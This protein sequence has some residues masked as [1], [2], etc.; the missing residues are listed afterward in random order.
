MCIIWTYEFDFIILWRSTGEKFLILFLHS[1]HNRF[2]REIET[3]P[4]PITNPPRSSVISGP[5]NYRPILRINNERDV[6]DSMFLLKVVMNIC[7]DESK[8]RPSEPLI[9]NAQTPSYRTSSPITPYDVVR[10]NECLAVR[11][12]QERRNFVV[13]LLNAD[14]FVVEMYSDVWILGDMFENYSGK[15]VLS[16]KNDLWQA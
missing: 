9:W 11:S 13:R 8:I 14:K 7:R 1:L 4:F 10:G 3:I 2:L 12:R 16:E 6:I 5:H 15:V